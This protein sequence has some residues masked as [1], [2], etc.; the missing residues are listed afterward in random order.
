MLNG[1]IIIIISLFPMNY[2]NTFQNYKYKLQKSTL[3]SLLMHYYMYTNEFIK[4]IHV[5]NMKCDLFCKGDLGI[6]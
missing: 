5:G 2:F 4:F 3:F 1:I 6:V